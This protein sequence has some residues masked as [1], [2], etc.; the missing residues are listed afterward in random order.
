ML[1]CNVLTLF[2]TSGHLQMAILSFGRSTVPLLETFLLD[3]HCYLFTPTDEGE[4]KKSAL[5]K[6]SYGRVEGRVLFETLGMK[7]PN[8]T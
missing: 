8:V 4:K 2:L 5:S 6:H 3:S 1:C 7:I